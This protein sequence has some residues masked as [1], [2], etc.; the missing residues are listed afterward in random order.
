M[1]PVILFTIV[2]LYFGLLLVVAW[3]T[4]RKGNN[5]GF[6]IGN[7]NSHWMLVAFGMIGLFLGP[8]VIALALA[9]INFTQDTQQPKPP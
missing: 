4:S 3:Q 7:R 1:S 9:L 5:A 6:F 8:V 2:M